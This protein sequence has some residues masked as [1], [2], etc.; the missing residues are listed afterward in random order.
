MQIMEKKVPGEKV[1][2][3]L[4]L[5]IQKELAANMKTD[6]KVTVAMQWKSSRSL[7]KEGT[8]PNKSNA[9]RADSP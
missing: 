3:D 2:L 5:S 8:W 9:F 7:R 4:I 6:G 1:F